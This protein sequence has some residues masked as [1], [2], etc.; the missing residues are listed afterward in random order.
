LG[1][2]AAA[3]LPRRD[4]SG[5]AYHLPKLYADTPTALTFPGDGNHVVYAEDITWATAT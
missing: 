1:H 5:S 4:P 2:A 3:F